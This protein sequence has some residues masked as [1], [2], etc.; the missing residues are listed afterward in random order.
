M[1]ER[2]RR[3]ATQELGGDVDTAHAS[4]DRPQPL[5]PVLD[6][7]LLEVGRQEMTDAGWDER[8]HVDNLQS[9]P[10]A[11]SQVCGMGQ[12]R[13][14]EATA[15][16]S[17]STLASEIMNPPPVTVHHHSNGTAKDVALRSI[18]HHP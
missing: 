3:A 7:L 13:L 15:S 8:Q 17:T 2:C 6:K 14:F 18:P 16:T 4:C 9:C 5:A 10:A 11:N 12:G 1:N